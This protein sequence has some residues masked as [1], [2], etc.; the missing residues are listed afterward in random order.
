VL[1]IGVVLGKFW[2]ML[3]SMCERGEG[4]LLLMKLVWRI[5]SCWK[6]CTLCQLLA[7]NVCQAT[8]LKHWPS[9]S[10]VPGCWWA[11]AW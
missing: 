6:S 1:A 8:C 3:Y 5:A 11:A 10:Q 9:L 2:W 7:A 4:I